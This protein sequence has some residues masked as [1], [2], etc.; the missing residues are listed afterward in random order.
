MRG[1]RSVSVAVTDNGVDYVEAD[2]DYVYTQSAVVLSLSVTE[3]PTIGGTVVEVRGSNFVDA[4]EL[5]CKFDTTVVPAKFVS[6]T[7]LAC[8]S[9]PHSSDRVT[10]DVSISYFNES[11]FLLADSPGI[12]RCDCRCR[13]QKHKMQDSKY[14][15]ACHIVL[16]NN[17][18]F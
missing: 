5:R 14:G 18:V 3:G 10:V 13:R 8:V 7:E 12:C 9:P 15:P 4:P 11:A 6:S 17:Q 16:L 2:L 1:S